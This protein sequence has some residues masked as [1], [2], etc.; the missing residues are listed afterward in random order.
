MATG[1]RTVEINVQVFDLVCRGAALDRVDLTTYLESIVM[2]HAEYIKSRE[3]ME[4][5][6]PLAQD[7]QNDHGARLAA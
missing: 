2:R 6:E 7:G 3:F 4:G 1:T 5:V